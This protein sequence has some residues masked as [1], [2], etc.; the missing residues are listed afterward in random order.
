MERQL[1]L[2]LVEDEQVLR[3]LVAEFLRRA[4]YVVAEAADGPKALE[5]YRAEGPFDALMVDLNLPGYSGAEVCRRVRRI[6]PDQ[7]ILVASAAIL[8]EHRVILD[9]VGNIEK[10]TK[11]YHPEILLARL[12]ALCAQR[13]AAPPAPG[14]GPTELTVA[15]AVPLAT[16][17]AVE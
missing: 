5:R 14:F 15:H 10:L 6:D 1:T 4:G 7:P 3:T 16:R 17:T 8:P 2:L 12:D 11:P 13:P 9:A